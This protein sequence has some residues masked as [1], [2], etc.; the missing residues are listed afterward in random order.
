[1]E[2]LDLYDKS[3][4]KLN[5]TIIRGNKPNENEYIKITVVY[6]KA[7][8]KYLVQKCS[9]AKGGEYAITGGHVS[10]GNTSSKQAV[11]EVQE[12]LGLD[13]IEEKL[14]LLGNIYKN[15]AMFDIYLYEDDSLINANTTLQLEEVESIEWL[16]KT[17][18][19]NLIAKGLVRQSS[20]IHYEKYIK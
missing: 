20:V 2:I 16:T 4:N 6:L 1:M 7:Q 15:T 13:I 12:E 10:S 19:E 11:I 5:K 3:G 8:D 18:I 9:E 14:Q 17:E